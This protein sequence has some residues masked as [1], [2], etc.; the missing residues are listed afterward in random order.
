MID[1]IFLQKIINRSFYT[2]KLI[3]Y[4]WSPVIKVLVWQRRVGKSYIL[5]SMVKYLVK[6]QIIPK[7]NIFYINKEL[8]EYDNI[9]DY[10]DLNNEFEKFVKNIWHNR[11]VIAI[12]EIQVIKN[13]E[14]FI[15]SCLSKYWDRA[16]IYITWSNSFLLSSELSTYISGRYISIFVLPLSFDEFCQFSSK[17]NNKNTF[18]EYLKYWW[19]PW[20]FQMN[21]SDET[22]F[23]YLKSIYNTI[24]LKDII[25]HFNIKN[26]DF[27]D[28]LYKY[29]LTNIGNIFSAKNISDYLK[30]QKLTT[31]IDTV[32]N[33]LWYGQNA[34]I[35]HKVKTVDTKS[36]KYFEIYNKYYSNDLWIR[37]SITGYILSR[38]IWLLL[39]NYIYI[40]LSK[41]WFDIYI[42][43]LTNN[44]EIDFI[45]SKNGKTIYIQVS[46]TIMDPNTLDREYRPLEQITDNWPKYVVTLDDQN[47]GIKEGIIHSNIILFE[48]ILYEFCNIE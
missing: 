6:N 22:I 38:D 48:K 19:M 4:I 24:L 25:S 14:K 11:F 31:S 35:I 41:H 47:F 30:S 29:T 18:F 37:N 12:D 32:L 7:D 28:E 40:L 17:E 3:K 15:N 27:F 8:I 46:T 23:N 13:W 39:E 5:K 44:Q 36:K 33:Y 2:D 26:L 20:I 43:R 10:Q 45:A 9:C 16:E 21:R 34:F 42:W 1:D